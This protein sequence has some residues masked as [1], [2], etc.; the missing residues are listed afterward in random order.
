MALTL[1]KPV[2]F[3]TIESLVAY[4][5]E[6]GLHLYADRP[7]LMTLDEMNHPEFGA[8]QQLMIAKGYPDEVAAGVPESGIY[9]EESDLWITPNLHDAAAELLHDDTSDLRRILALPIPRSFL[10]LDVS[11][12]S[13]QKVGRQTLI[14]NS[15]ITMGRH[16]GHPD[17]PESHD[18][19]AHLEAQMCIG[20]GYIYV[21]PKAVDAA[22]FAGLFADYIEKMRARRKLPFP[23]HFRMGIH[24]GPVYCFWDF[25]RQSWNYVGEGINGGSRVISAIGKDLDDVI[26]VSSDIREEIMA[27]N[28]GVHR[29]A[30]ILGSLHNR[31]RRADKHGNLWR[32]YELNFSDLCMGLHYELEDLGAAR[33][34][35]V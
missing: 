33:R 7:E 14:I 24:T 28:T 20:D 6:N 31:G 11:D 18:C 10:Y 23:F 9:G 29:M 22:Y 26:F 1:S 13:Q 2:V 27:E 15:I 25:G 32:V 30:R 12:F 4:C 35:A 19:L 8:I 5:K 17:F 3:T 21:F 16:L 34:P